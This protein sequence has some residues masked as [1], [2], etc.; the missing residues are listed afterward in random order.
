M[1][2]TE[3]EQQFIRNNAKGIDTEQLTKMLNKKFDTNYSN[4]KVY[5]W[6]KRNHICSGVNTRFKKGNHPHNYKPIGS[7]FI[8]TEGYTF[9]KVAEPNVWK[10]KTTVIYE[11][12]YGSI[13]E[14]YCVVFADRD[15]TNFN[16]DN[17]IL[18]RNKD[19]LTAKNK[20]LLSEDKELTKTGLL[21]AELINKA[22][23]KKGKKYE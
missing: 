11:R 22:A 20:H 9:V 23:E 15:K 21:V 17:L 2:F 18:V 4:Y 14:G 1:R 12:Y 19:K 5:R 6:K 16:L 13:P 10:H 3:E 7:E 8:S